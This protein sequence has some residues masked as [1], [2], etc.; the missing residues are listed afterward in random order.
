M[1][2][3]K[4]NK[5]AAHVHLQL[6]THPNLPSTEVEDFE[7]QLQY[8]LI[9]LYYKIQYQIKLFNLYIHGYKSH[10]RYLGYH[11]LFHGQ[12]APAKLTTKQEKH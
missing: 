11:L 4:P 3:E 5:A 1:N 12:I 6:I 9:T 8:H 10:H 2:M 7:S